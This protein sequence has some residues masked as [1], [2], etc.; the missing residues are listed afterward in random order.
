MQ[1]N[2]LF[3]ESINYVFLIDIYTNRLNANDIQISDVNERNLIVRKLRKAH[4]TQSQ[5]KSKGYTE[6]R[7]ILIIKQKFFSK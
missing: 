2:E 6:N 4:S 7:K 3:N 1:T 5:N